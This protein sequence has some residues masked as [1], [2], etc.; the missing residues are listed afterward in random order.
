MMSNRERQDRL[1]CTVWGED[2]VP[3][4]AKPKRRRHV[5]VNKQT[6]PQRCN[7]GATRLCEGESW[8]PGPW[9]KGGKPAPF[10]EA[11]R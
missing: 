4:D 8:R 7:C 6:S 2:S 10:C 1:T 9:R 3:P 11:E 5:V